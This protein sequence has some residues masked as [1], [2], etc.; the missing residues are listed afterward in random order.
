MREAWLD[1]LNPPPSPT[2]RL[3]VAPEAVSRRLLTIFFKSVSS[4]YGADPV[5]IL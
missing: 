1:A 3:H 2:R 5:S 4:T